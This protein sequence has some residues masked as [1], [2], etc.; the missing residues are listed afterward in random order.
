MEPLS[1]TLSLAVEC[2]SLVISPSFSVFSVFRGF[3]C[4]FQ[5]EPK[6]PHRE[7]RAVDLQPLTAIQ[8]KNF[9]PNPAHSRA[10]ITL[11]VC[12]TICPSTTSRQ[13][14]SHRTTPLYMRG[15]INFLIRIGKTLRRR[16]GIGVVELLVRHSGPSRTCGFE[17]C[18][19]LASAHPCCRPRA[20]TRRSA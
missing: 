8:Q 12:V 20:L 13:R 17:S 10:P 19:A 7:K 9:T 16:G 4:P 11:T 6:A 1:P 3:N 14:N 15:V 2:P 18:C 5:D